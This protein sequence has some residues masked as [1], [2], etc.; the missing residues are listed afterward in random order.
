MYK[1]FTLTESER[2]Q[3][4]NMHQDKGY[5]QPMNEQQSTDDTIMGTLPS[6]LGLNPSQVLKDTSGNVV[7]KLYMGNDGNKG[8]TVKIMNNSNDAIVFDPTLKGSKTMSLQQ[9]VTDFKSRTH[10][11]ISGMV[12]KGNTPQP[13]NK[14]MSDDNVAKLNAS[15]KY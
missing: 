11:W 12:G 13:E 5:R 2:E 15:I 7:G 1:N 9:V 8:Y 10:Q 14:Y 6:K 4:L 3:I